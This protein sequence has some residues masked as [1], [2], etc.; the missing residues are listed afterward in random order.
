MHACAHVCLSVALCTRVYALYV[1]TCTCACVPVCLGK[2]SPTPFSCW[3]S[4]SGSS[5][6]SSLRPTFSSWI[7]CGPEETGLSGLRSL[8]PGLNPFPH[9]SWLPCPPADPSSPVHPAP[10]PSAY[11][12]IRCQ[13]PLL[14]GTF[15][16]IAVLLHK[17]AANSVPLFCKW[18]H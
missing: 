13:A 4:V 1:L 11:M 8:Q 3:A 12:F 16:L 18:G 2:V 15:S 17:A 6:P 10:C 5:E 14:K 9:L 7:P